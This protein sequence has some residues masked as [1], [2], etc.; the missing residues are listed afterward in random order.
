MKCL[1]LLL[2]LLVSYAVAESAPGPLVSPEEVEGAGA[3]PYE[4]RAKRPL[5][6]PSMSG[7]PAPHPSARRRDNGRG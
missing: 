1:V 6:E 2:A 3:E 7:D 4:I 5:N